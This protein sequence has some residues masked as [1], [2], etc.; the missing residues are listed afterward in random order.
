MQ[1]SF[2][3]TGDFAGWGTYKGEQVDDCP[4]DFS[5]WNVYLDGEQFGNYFCKSYSSWPEYT[6]SD[7]GIPFKFSF[8][9]G[10]TFS[11]VYRFYT[12]GNLIVCA[13]FDGGASG[14]SVSAGGETVPYGSDLHIDIHYYGLDRM[15]SGGDWIDITGGGTCVDPGYRVRTID[16]DDRWVEDI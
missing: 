5:G 13:D 2:P 4:A 15:T 7:N 11:N 9:S 14:G 3:T 8:G 10:C 12:E 16:P 6:G 1:I